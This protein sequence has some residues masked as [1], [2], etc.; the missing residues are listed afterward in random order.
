M[1]N[2]ECFIYE[3]ATAAWRHF[4][5]NVM[6]ESFISCLSFLFFSLFFLSVLFFKSSDIEQSSI[7]PMESNEEP[8]NYQ[9]GPTFFCVFCIFAVNESAVTNAVSSTLCGLAVV[10]NQFTSSKT[11]NFNSMKPN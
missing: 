1:N 10:T 3:M 2:T 11:P 9:K 7:I 8:R 6:E 4:I 5:P